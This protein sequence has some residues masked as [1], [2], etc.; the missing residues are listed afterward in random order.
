MPFSEKSEVSH[1]QPGD[2]GFGYIND[3]S[4]RESVTMSMNPRSP[5]KSAMRAPGT[6]GRSLANPLSPTFLEEQ[7]LE[8]KEFSTEREQARDLVR[9]FIMA[10][11]K[12][13]RTH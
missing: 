6:P 13:L 4:T 9:R 10:Y 12:C 5:P 1:A 2:L 8:T 3:V 11:E 7:A